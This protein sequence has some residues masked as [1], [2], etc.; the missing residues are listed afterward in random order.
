MLVSALRQPLDCVVMLLIVAARAKGE[1]AFPAECA[2]SVPTA[3]S[4]CGGCD[5]QRSTGP[6]CTVFLS[7]CAVSTRFITAE[8][9]ACGAE[10]VVDGKE[11]GVLRSSDVVACEF[12]ACASSNNAE[13]VEDG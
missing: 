6:L 7:K 8:C 11:F 9:Q 5:W 10:L 2:P 3:C 4:E 13:T 1:E 12:C